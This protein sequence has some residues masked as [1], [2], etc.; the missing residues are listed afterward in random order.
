MM[1]RISV[2]IPTRNRHDELHHTLSH[3]QES[4]PSLFSEDPDQYTPDV[5]VI[6]N[7]SDTP[8]T[9]QL[10]KDLASMP[11]LQVIRLDENHAAAGRNIGAQHAQGD[12]IMMLD[13]DSVPTSGPFNTILSSLPPDVLALGGEILL[14]DQSHEQGGL[15][16]VVIGCGCLYRKDAFLSAGG[17]DP[18]FEY[19]VEEYDL[20]ARLIQSGGRVAHTRALSFEHRKVQQNR[21]FRM[22]LKRIVRNNIWVIDRYC[23]PE[24]R[25]R[26][27]SSMLDR[28]ER[29]ARTKKMDEHFAEGVLQANNAPASTSPPLTKAHWDRFVGKQAVK[30]SLLN[31]LVNGAI[32]EVQLVRPGKGA[33]TIEEALREAGVSI[34]DRAGHKVIATLSP[35]PMIDAHIEDPDRHRGWDFIEQ[36]QGM[37]DHA[38]TV[39]RA[40]G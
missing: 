31:R 13:D 29:I 11:G 8:V 7:A 20:C 5:L 37:L 28:Y 24:L 9:S 27:M 22:I 40:G 18:A 17:Y 32:Q 36:Q 10:P 33:E 38:P 1:P 21:D 19:Y 2:V 4:A 25:D 15:P 14:P 30:D 23:P 3:L 34:T 6:D 35:G 16:E 12:W 26:S 39:S